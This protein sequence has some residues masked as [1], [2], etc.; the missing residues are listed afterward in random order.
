MLKSGATAEMGGACSVSAV[1]RIL[2]AGMNPMAVATWL[3]K[4]PPPARPVLHRIGLVWKLR[5]KSR[6]FGH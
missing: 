3:A 2:M 1:A 6:P 4:E 5:V